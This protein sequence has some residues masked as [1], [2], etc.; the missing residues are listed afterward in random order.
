MKTL[1]D[2]AFEAVDRARMADMAQPGSL[3]VLAKA[4]QAVSVFLA[5]THC[6]SVPQGGVGIEGIGANT[7]DADE[8]SAAIMRAI[9]VT[10]D[11]NGSLS[12][13]APVALALEI[14]ACADA[15][16]FN[17]ATVPAYTLR[18]WARIIRGWA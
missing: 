6:N 11:G 16:D 14:G 13:D 18:E 8:K 7:G 1:A 10:A 2:Q 12:L 3:A 9:E 5:E 4:N 17:A 15:V